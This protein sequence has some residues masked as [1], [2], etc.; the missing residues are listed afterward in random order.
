MPTATTANIASVPLTPR[1]ALPLPPPPPARNDDLPLPRKSSLSTLRSLGKKGS[2]TTLRSVKIINASSQ[3]PAGHPFALP[4]AVPSTPGKARTAKSSIGPPKYVPVVSPSKFLDHLPRPAPTTPKRETFSGAGENEATPDLSMTTDVD[5]SFASSAYI[6]TPAAT[7]LHM[8]STPRVNDVYT[9]NSKSPSVAKSR[10]LLGLLP[11]KP[12]LENLPGATTDTPSLRK[13]RSYGPGAFLGFNA[14]T[15]SPALP[16][17]PPSLQ[18]RRPLGV[19]GQSN[20]QPVHRFSPHQGG[21]R[22]EGQGQ[23]AASPFTPPSGKEN[24]SRFFS[25]LSSGQYSYSTPPLAIKRGKRVVTDFTASPMSTDGDVSMD[26]I[27]MEMEMD[28]SPIK[29]PPVQ[30]GKSESK[31][32]LRSGMSGVSGVSLVTHETVDSGRTNWELE[33]YLESEQGHP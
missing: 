20:A 30:H 4:P 22:G 11:R 3:I 24:A 10:R 29:T 15:D 26:R 2:T 19:I 9:P 14:G 13:K 32:S 7:H 31:S 16:S 18:T 27:L 33:R 12:T 1:P 17:M 5:S 21:P 23:P 28:T 6:I 8:P 25:D